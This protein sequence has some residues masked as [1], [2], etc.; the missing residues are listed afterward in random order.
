MSRAAVTFVNGAVSIALIGWVLSGLTLS[1]LLASATKAHAG[2]LALA[3]SL[4]GTGLLLSATRWLTFLNIQKLETSFKAAI[5]LYWIGCFF[6]AVLPTGLGGDVV[7]SYLAFKQNGKAVDTA[8]SVIFERVAG[9]AALIIIFGVTVVWLHFFSAGSSMWKIAGLGSAG[10][11]GAG[12]VS[13]AGKARWKT[14]LA[15]F[16]GR[17]KFHRIGSVLRT[18]KSHKRQLWRILILSLLLQINVIVYYYIIAAALDLQLS[19][20]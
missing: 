3:L 2:L 17:E 10:M 19:F 11:I 1:E 14:A 16:A 13:I 20:F 4:H 6:N 5:L 9:V 18:Y 12:W 15:R 8:V 7:R